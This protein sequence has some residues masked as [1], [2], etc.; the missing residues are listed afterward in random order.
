M[1]R[2]STITHC[3]PPKKFFLDPTPPS[4]F[5]V[6]LMVSRNIS[7]FWRYSNFQNSFKLP[8]PEG[9]HPLKFIEEVHSEYEENEVQI[10]L[11]YHG[12]YLRVITKANRVM[13]FYDPKV[14]PKYKSNCILKELIAVL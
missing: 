3:E 7:N 14:A 8:K 13:R 5:I 9:F 2:L 4:H 11:R 12:E 6:E 10:P 1:S